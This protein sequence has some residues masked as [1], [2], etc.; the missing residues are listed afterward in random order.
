MD[1]DVAFEMNVERVRRIDTTCTVRLH[2]KSNQLNKFI[3]F[4]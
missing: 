4:L 2:Q 1:S 3:R